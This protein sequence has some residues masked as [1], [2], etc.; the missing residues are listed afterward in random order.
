VTA[1]PKHVIED[2]QSLPDAAK[3]EV[4]A[5]L[6]RISRHIEYPSLTD[7]ELTSIADDIFLTYDKGETS[8]QPA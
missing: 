8:G 3:R 6:V 2:F 4:L 7:E 5:E 1:D